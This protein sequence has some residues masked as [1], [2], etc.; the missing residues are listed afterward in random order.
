M[1]TVN[2]A[3]GVYT[4]LGYNFNDPNG[5]V[6]N[7]SAN[8][9]THLNTMPA[10]IE[11]WQAQDIANNAVGGYFQNPLN[12]QINTIITVSGQ[13]VIIANTANGMGYTNALTVMDSANTLLT[14]SQS[15]LAHTNRLSGI[16]PFDGTDLVNPYYDTAINY[17]KTALYITNQTDAINNTSPIMGSFTSLFIGPQ[18][19]SY[20]NTLSA[21]LV[22][23]TAAVMGSTLTDALINQVNT[24]INNTN[25]LMATRQ[26]ADITYYTNLKAFTA[27]YNTVKQFS[28]MGESQSYLLNNF[29]GTPKLVSRINS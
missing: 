25:T 12:T 18:I 20:A 16:T 3:T 21:D 13:L 17:G 9:Q 5:Y 7:L 2:N 8:S 26:N 19:Y 4:T 24:D 1:A 28:N 15:F 29:I 23:F 22:T 11:T 27:N 14:Q 6:Q 10:F